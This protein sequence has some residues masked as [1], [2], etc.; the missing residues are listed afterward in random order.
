MAAKKYFI[1]NIDSESGTEEIR[2]MTKQE[3]DAYKTDA[4]E[5]ELIINSIKDK[6][7]KKEEAIAKL[8]AL[9]LTEDDIRAMGI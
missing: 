6:A 5:A 8:V 4:A 2:E 9:G 3:S 1:T 7:R